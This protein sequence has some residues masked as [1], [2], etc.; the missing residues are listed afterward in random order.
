MESM[1]AG[2]RVIEFATVLAAPSASAALADYGAEVIKVESPQGDM[3]RYEV[4]CL[5]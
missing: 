2:V 3:W 5:A 1:L 4:R